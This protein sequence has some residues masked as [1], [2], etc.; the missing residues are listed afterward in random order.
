MATVM[1]VATDVIQDILFN[2]EKEASKIQVLAGSFGF[3]SFVHPEP[4]QPDFVAR[5]HPPEPS[6]STDANDEREPRGSTYNFE[7]DP[8]TN[9]SLRY[10]RKRNATRD[11]KDIPILPN[12]RAQK[13]SRY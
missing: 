5:A 8:D 11:A 9:R 6:R 12:E 3:D 10:R 13:C 2:G 4:M 1:R 7:G